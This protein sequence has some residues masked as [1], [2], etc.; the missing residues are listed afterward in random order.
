MF[1]KNE[2]TFILTPHTLDLDA[3]IIALLFCHYCS[4]LCILCIVL[5]FTLFSCFY[6]CVFCIPFFELLGMLYFRPRVYRQLPLYLYEVG[7]RSAYT[8]PSSDLTLLDYTGYCCCC[9]FTKEVRT[10]EFRIV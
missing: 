9:T 8:L 3:S 1:M 6:C 5:Y 2:I 4:Y 7:V 10:V